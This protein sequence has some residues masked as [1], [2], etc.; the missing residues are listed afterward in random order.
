VDIVEV[1]A[2]SDEPLALL[3]GTSAEST[4]R[5][6]LAV[7]YTRAVMTD[8]NSVPEALYAQIKRAFTDPEV[9]ELTFLIGYI[10]ML[11]LFNNSLGVRY[12]G[13]YRVLASAAG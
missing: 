6:R 4:D 9:V 2:I 1:E 5:E 12:H 10:N 3:N 8:S 11:N 7:E 13:D